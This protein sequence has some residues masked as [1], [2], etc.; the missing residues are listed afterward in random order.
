M[1]KQIGAC[2]Q[3]SGMVSQE[4]T[5]QHQND[6]GVLVSVQPSNGATELKAVQRSLEKA[7]HEKQVD[8]SCHGFGQGLPALGSAEHLDGGREFL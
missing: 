7:V 6:R 8:V 4:M 2:G 1:Q 3:A 5:R